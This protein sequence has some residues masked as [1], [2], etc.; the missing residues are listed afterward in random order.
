MSV[1]LQDHLS[2]HIQSVRK[3]YDHVQTHDPIRSNIHW[4]QK[5]FIMHPPLPMIIFP[6]IIYCITYF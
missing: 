3:L 6:A 2:T 4:S 5:S 1:L